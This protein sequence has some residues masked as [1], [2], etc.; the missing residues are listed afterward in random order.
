MAVQRS[1]SSTTD[2]AREFIESMKD[3]RDT[4]RDERAKRLAKGPAKARL[5]YHSGQAEASGRATHSGGSRSSRS[6][7]RSR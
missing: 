2:T 5:T 3:I 7:R 4:V 6:R 1:S